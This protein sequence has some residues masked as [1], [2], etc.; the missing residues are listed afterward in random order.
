METHEDA[1]ARDAARC[2]FL[3]SD[4]RHCSGKLIAVLP[5]PLSL[6]VRNVEGS[7]FTSGAGN[8][9]FNNNRPKASGV[10]PIALYEVNHRIIDEIDILDLE[11][12]TTSRIGRSLD[13]DALSPREGPS[14]DGLV[15]LTWIVSWTHGA[16]NVP[17]P[18]V[19]PDLLDHVLE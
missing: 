5:N 17:V 19:Q 1:C 3:D 8:G 18:V 2:D 11:P 4:L 16:N 7:N 13:D 10:L 12:S 15:E 6:S 14:D 9:A